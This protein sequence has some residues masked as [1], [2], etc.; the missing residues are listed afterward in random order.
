[1][2]DRRDE[3][4][5]LEKLFNG[6]TVSYDRMNKLLSLGMDQRWRRRAARIVA[7]GKPSAVLDLCTGTG[8]LAYLLADTL[9]EGTRVVGLDYSPFMLDKAK[10]K[11]PHWKKTPFFVLGDASALHFPANSFDAVAI[12]FAFR[13]LTYHNPRMNESLAEIRRVLKPDGL[14]VIVES[15]QPRMRIIRKLR[16]LYVEIMLGKIV[17]TLSG[18]KSAYR[19][20][21]D[22]VKRYYDPLEIRNLL[23][24]AG[25]ESVIFTPLF[26]GAVGPYT[27]GS[28]TRRTY[29]NQL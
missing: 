28:K 6:I 19:Y 13:N 17:G 20:L 29:E 3:N 14:F 12:S 25:F 24:S 23:Q 8:D 4:R 18:H 5:P 15:A 11:E 7:D 26:F 16:D 10:M 2:T 27:A 1:M 21:A 9:E 22:S